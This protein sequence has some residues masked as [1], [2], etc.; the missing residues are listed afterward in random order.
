MKIRFNSDDVLILGKNHKI[1]IVRYLSGQAGSGGDTL[2]RGTG[3]Y[4]RTMMLFMLAKRKR[5]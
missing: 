1:K 2:K 3:N 4:L 5:F